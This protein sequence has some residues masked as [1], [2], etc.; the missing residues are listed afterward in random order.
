MKEKRKE[1]KMERI[2]YSIK[3][4]SS[5]TG[6]PRTTIY[7]WISAGKIPALKLYGKMLIP[8]RFVDSL[9]L[10]TQAAEVEEVRR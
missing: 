2:C 3:E 8:A 1:E 10:R 6:I 4:F 7:T 5:M 9:R